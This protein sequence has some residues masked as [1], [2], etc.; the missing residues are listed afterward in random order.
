MVRTVKLI[1]IWT[2][3][4]LDID[5]ECRRHGGEQT[6]LPFLVE[7]SIVL[8]LLVEHHVEESAEVHFWRFIQ[9]GEL[10]N[11]NAQNPYRIAQPE[12]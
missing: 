11:C 10:L 8:V 5:R 1:S 4:L 6:G 9:W 12:R 2:Q 7:V 3:F